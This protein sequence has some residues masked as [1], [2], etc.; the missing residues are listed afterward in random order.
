MIYFEIYFYILSTYIFYDLFWNTFLYSIRIY[1]L[2]F[3]VKYIF[4]HLNIF[5]HLFLFEYI[6]LS[7]YLFFHFLKNYVIISIR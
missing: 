5:C 6:L 2:L 3:I 7:I 1:I 4:F